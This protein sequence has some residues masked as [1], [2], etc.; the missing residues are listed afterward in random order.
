[1]NLTRIADRA[2]AEV[3]ARGAIRSR[4]FPLLPPRE[5]HHLADVGSGGGVP[6]I[7]LAIARPDVGI[8]LIESTQKKAGF[9]AR[10]PMIWD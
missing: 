4:C 8:A 6:G 2:A 1:M 5:A 7:P 3:A 9:L 10:Q